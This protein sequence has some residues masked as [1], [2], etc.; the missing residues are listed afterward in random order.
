MESWKFE[1]VQAPERPDRG[2]LLNELAKCHRLVVG[3]AA[4]AAVGTAGMRFS[5][6][7]NTLCVTANVGGPVAHGWLLA[8]A[9]WLVQHGGRLSALPSFTT[10]AGQPVSRAWLGGLVSTSA[11]VGAILRDVASLRGAIGAVVVDDHYGAQ[12][13]TSGRTGRLAFWSLGAP[14]AAAAA[15]KWASAVAAE[16]DRLDSGFAKALLAREVVRLPASV[17]LTGTP[18]QVGGVMLQSM[19]LEGTPNRPTLD[20]AFAA[21]PTVVGTPFYCADY[22]DW[23]VLV[24][25]DGGEAARR[26]SHVVGVVPGGRYQRGHFPFD[27]AAATRAVE[28]FVDRL[29]GISLFPAAR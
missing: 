23:G 2:A 25:V 13:D 3:A 27:A 16:V 24:V 9:L 18:R 8:I 7:N 19:V 10:L 29:G 12:I 17:C 14:S 4:V 15:E 11:D 1:M 28:S 26:F 20:R 5:L 22:G 6:N 21:P